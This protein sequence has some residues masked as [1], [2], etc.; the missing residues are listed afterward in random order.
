MFARAVML[1]EAGA[2][3]SLRWLDLRIPGARRF[4]LGEFA[5]F[6][7]VANCTNSVGFA[8]CSGVKELLLP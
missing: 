2:E 6:A 1:T 8:S 5:Q 3:F 4:D 7:L